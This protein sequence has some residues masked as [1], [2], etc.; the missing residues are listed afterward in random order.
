MIDDWRVW[1]ALRAVPWRAANG[2]LDRG[3]RMSPP[4]LNS[5][6][7]TQQAFLDAPDHLVTVTQAVTADTTNTD[8]GD[9]ESWD[10][11][12]GVAGQ[13]VDGWGV[14]RY[15]EGRL[16]EESDG[17]VSTGIDIFAPAGTV[18]RAPA[19]G[20]VA[21]TGDV[22]S[23]RLDDEWTLAVR[24][25]DITG[26][27]DDV[28]TGDVLGSVAPTP[29]DA[30]PSAFVQ[31]V[32]D[33]ELI[34]PRLAP[35]ELG[36]RFA[37]VDPRQWLGLSAADTGDAT[38]DPA[39]AA[40]L[41]ERRNAVLA[42]AQE[43][44]YES[45]PRIER[46]RRH[47]MFDTEGRRYLDMV[48]NVTIVGHSHPAIESAVS[49]QLRLINT[50][51]RFHYEAIVEF[52]ERLTAL[53]PPALDTVLLVSTGSE[54][55]EVALRLIRAATGSDHIIA[56]CSAYHGWTTGTD[57]ISTSMAD[58]PG[59][60]E[61]RPPW[62]HVIESP[63]VV[64]GKHRGSDAGPSTRPKLPKRSTALVRTASSSVGSSPNPSMAM[65]AACSF[66]TATWTR[67]T[68]PCAQLVAC[69]SPM[70][71]KLDTADSVSSSGASSSRPSSPTS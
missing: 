1:R 8:N 38:R 25:I 34:P 21:V 20:P 37:T 41:L 46:A 6:A 28:K 13:L 51:S 33:A 18:V 24:G 50:N 43:H 3:S 56:V 44:Y 47:Y 53:L 68:K 66:P 52:S 30:P 9:P 31:L 19:P 55:N 29:G 16:A 2:V 42:K 10:I 65:P 27:G 67:S 64:R 40:D 17:G 61:T 23:L 35:S 7:A 14:G 45:P 4:R 71:C 60:A 59:A 22:L 49:R 54:A 63:N 69:V 70:K 32:A 26:V 62:V 57:A 15:G 5:L 11:G 39:T 48:N 12:E 58:N 36:W